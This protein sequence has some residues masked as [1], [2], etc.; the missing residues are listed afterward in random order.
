M[1]TPTRRNIARVDSIKKRIAFL[2]NRIQDG[3]MQDKDYSYDK[4]EASAL[5]WAVEIIESLMYSK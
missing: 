5:R 2:E 3:E 4:Q 1:I